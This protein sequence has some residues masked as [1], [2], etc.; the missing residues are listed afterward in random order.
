[1]IFLTATLI[2]IAIGVLSGFLAGLLGV[3]GG[4]VLV[5]A[6]AWAFELA[7]EPS[8]WVFRLALGTSMATILFTSL[9]SLLSHHRKEGVIWPIVG[10]FTPG[11][12]VGTLIGTFLA[13]H[14]PSLG[15]VIFFALFMG[16]V[17]FQ[18]I[19]EFKPKPGRVLPGKA[20]QLSVAA[21]IGCVSSL[22]AVGGAAMTVP[23]LTWCNVSIRKAIGTAAALGFPIAL[24]GT[25]GF[26]FNGWAAP[27]L[28]EGSVGF[29]YLPAL[30]WTVLASMLTAPLG[31]RATQVLPA[32]IL[33]KVFAVVLLCVSVEMLHGAWTK[34]S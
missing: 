6:L 15:L 3:G 28:P 32:H 11:I 26:V 29:V 22:V 21:L 4:S 5:P 16:L 34:L 14:V 8:Q 9:S 19:F 27:G 2:Y 18:M 12:L 23:F 24:G 10:T 17:A 30:V 7:H 20:G 13:R 25:L 33:R 31:A 1:M